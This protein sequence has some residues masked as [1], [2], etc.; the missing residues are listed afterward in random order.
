MPKR[1]LIITALCGLT[2]AL[3]AMAQRSSL[4]VKSE[5]GGI[6]QASASLIYS[7]ALQ[8]R[9]LKLN[10]LVTIRIN[11]VGSFISE[12]EIN[13]QINSNIDARLRNWLE[14]DGLNLIASPN[15]DLPRARGSYNVQ[16]QSNGELETREALQFNIT[17]R[18]VDIRPNGNL[19]LEAHK[20]VRIDDEIYD[21]SLTGIVRREDVDPQN[22]VLSER[23][24]EL[25][26][27]RKTIGQVRDSY[28]RGWLSRTWDL[29]TPF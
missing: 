9:E 7:E 12:G 3:P 17:A 11:E 20:T 29:V 10:D 18:I 26:I 25:S 15:A 6:T 13:R 4:Y 19:V 1:H 14:L 22:R 8:P 23:I 16:N 27:Y 2:V 5:A 28:K 24:A 21:N